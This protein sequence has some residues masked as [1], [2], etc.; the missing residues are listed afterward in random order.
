MGKIITLSIVQ[1]EDLKKKVD[2]FKEVEAE[3]VIFQ[4]EL[5][6][7]LEEHIVIFNEH[8]AE[9]ENIE[10]LEEVQTLAET[11]DDIRTKT[12]NTLV[13]QAVDFTVVF[14]SR[15]ILKTADARFTKIANELKRIKLSKEKEKSVYALLD[16]AGTNLGTAR[17]LS[18]DAITALKQ[19]IPESEVELETEDEILVEEGTTAETSTLVEEPLITNDEAEIASETD[20]EITTE[21]IT[22]PIIPNVREVTQLLLIATKSAYTEFLEIA[23]LL[24]EKE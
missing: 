24:K 12:Y 22:T 16:T 14:Q 13:M 4:N 5:I 21:E 1:T 15:T 3:L 18:I 8:Y 6:E 7:S 9:L 11:F 20:K 19:Y 10:T 23:D 17:R 2:L